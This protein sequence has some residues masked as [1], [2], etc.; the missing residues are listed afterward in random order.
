MAQGLCN[1]PATFQRVMHLVMRG[2]TWDRVLVYLDDVI[3]LARSFE[4]SLE[5]LELVLK[6]F[7]AHNLKL[8]PKKCALFCT[9]VRFLGRQVSRNGVSVTTD[10]V[11][12]V[13]DWPHPKNALEV[14][15]FT[16]FVNYHREFIPRLA[17]TIKPLY[18]LTKRGELFEWTG[19]CE[20]AFH[21]LKRVM[22]TTPVLAFPNNEDPFTLDTDASDFAIGAAL[23]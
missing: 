1:A 21:E 18:A 22:T 9:E 17:E 20:S 23:Y 5:N 14:T 12:C 15:K 6:R 19:S 8:K 10:H 2:L 3:V 16:G 11:K 4:E 13:Q 7:M